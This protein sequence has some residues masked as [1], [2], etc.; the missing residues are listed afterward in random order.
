MQIA[1]LGPLEV[2]VGGRKVSLT[3]PRLRTLLVRLAVD[4]PKPVSVP[5]LIDAVW[6]DEP[7]A[8][9]AN[10]LQSLMSRLRRAFAD[11]T[12]ITA[13]P[14]GY[15]LD[16]DRSSIDLHRFSELAAQARRLQRDGKPDQALSSCTAALALWRG[17][18]LADADGAAYAHPIISACQNQLLEVTG[19]RIDALLDLGRG[20][21]T[22]GELDQLISSH[23]LRER[24]VAQQIRALAGAGRVSEALAAYEKCRRY[25]A[26]ELGSDPG[27]ELQQLH[28]ALLRGDLPTAPVAESAAARPQQRTNLRAG[29]TSFIGREPELARIADSLASARLVTI[30]G[31]GGAGKTR[32]ATEAAL[33]W[34]Q[35][36]DQPA[37][38]IELAPVGSPENIPGAML[39]ALGIGDPSLHERSERVGTDELQRLLDHLSATNCLLVVD[40]CEHLI[41]GVA[42]LVEELLM[43]APGVR[44]LATSRE[45]L[46]LT[47]ET[48]CPLPPLTL[49]PVGTGVDQAAEYAAVRLWI[50]RA[51][52]IVPGYRL[53]EDDL[54][55][56]VEIVRRLDG[57]PLAIELAAAR[58]RVLP[59]DEI[60]RLLSDRF[61]LLT[62][63]NRTSLPRHRTLRAVVEWSWDLLTDSERLL[64]ERLAIFP[65]GANIESATAICADGRLPADDI[66]DLMINLADKSLLQH[67]TGTPFRFR[68]LETIREYGIERLDERGELAIARS[69]HADYFFDLVLELE[70]Q[71]RDHRQRGARLVMDRE[72][73]NILAG[74]RYLIDGGDPHRALIMVLGLYWHYQIR[75][76]EQELSYWM[77]Q[78]IAANADR[79]E[80]LLAY[81]EALQ[82]MGELQR[83]RVHDT[84][85]TKKT[86]K[87]V[88]T[89]LNDAPE[90]PFPGLEVLRARLPIFLADGIPPMELLADRAAETE[91]PWI[92]GAI[93]AAAS[94]V[95]ENVGSWDAMA[96]YTDQAYQAFSQ[97]GDAWGL[98]AVL[99]QRAQLLTIEGRTDDAIAALEQALELA[100]A[101]G[102]GDDLLITH[103]RLAGLEIRRGDPVAAR[104]HV[105]LMRA[106]G[107]NS[108][109]DREKDLLCD[110]VDAI[111]LLAEG[112]NAEASEL[113]VRLRNGIDDE[114]LV[115]RFSAHAAAIA[116]A[117]TAQ[118]EL[119]LVPAAEETSGAGERTRQALADLRRG[120]PAAVIT[121][122]VPILA[123]FAAVVAAAAYAVG[124]PAL[125]ARLLG[126]S[127][128]TVGIE[129]LSDPR[130]L[131]LA[132]QLRTSLGADCF[133]DQF[134][135]GQK[136][137]S[138]EVVELMDP[139]TLDTTP[140]P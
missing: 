2:S 37:W 121:Q 104:E 133:D 14:A 101:I 106:S 56:V 13:E 86:L 31:P 95:A 34:M 61:R 27:P 116:L 124:R 58:L 15:R 8:D 97:T 127:A 105:R 125:A 50:D 30:V 129:Q 137:T 134:A 130:Q 60:A 40:N 119:A 83:V 47:A 52:A 17:E 18:P 36:Q 109:M 112:R 20:A 84:Q 111:V 76:Q 32:I 94:W 115:N 51:S 117:S 128:R 71:F 122:D 103:L 92:R 123:E 21:E 90:P 72:R 77:D 85:R 12:L 140:D 100:P 59:V 70:P 19:T 75:D 107:A 102:G 35:D 108:T 23:P 82:T 135:S 44:V 132:D 55:A 10:A 118:V 69:R 120:Y 5:E 65:A 89:R 22:I 63:G 16:A 66:A 78:V 64:A 48:L 139:E 53:S 87:N 9:A 38:M 42:R 88:I 43:L 1:I 81:A 110:S 62:G 54:P 80:P 99:S 114:M 126:G 73:G 28:L 67:A 24:F 74:L 6:E 39:G 33:H 41:D 7:P 79:D 26:D 25:L 136:L 45:P 113:A 68:M 98:S 93:L 57:L 4:A 96:H 11:P 91:D 46:A 3:G 49:P 138:D 131:R 29:L